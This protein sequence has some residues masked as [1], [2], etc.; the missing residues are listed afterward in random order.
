VEAALALMHEHINFLR[1]AQSAFGVWLITL[2]F[3]TFTLML[4]AISG[5]KGLASGMGSAVTFTLYLITSLVSS[6]SWLKTPEKFSPFHYYNNPAVA[7][8]GLNGGH[9]ALLFGLIV[10]MVIIALLAFNR[11]DVYQR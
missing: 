10:I 3:A 6:V 2:V 4:G 1:L 11:R 5:K 9:V 7:Q 8:Y